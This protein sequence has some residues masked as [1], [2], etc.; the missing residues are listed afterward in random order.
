MSAF[1]K[2]MVEIAPSIGTGHP[3]WLIDY[4]MQV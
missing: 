3:V 1:Q 2:C 4:I